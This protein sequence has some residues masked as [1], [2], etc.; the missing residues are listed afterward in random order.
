[1]KRFFTHAARRAAACGAVLLSMAFGVHAQ[2]GSQPSQQAL[3]QIAGLIAEKNA[4]TPAQQKIDSQLLYAAS[5]ARTGVASAAAPQM[6]VDGIADA[7]GRVE[8]E[9][10]GP[11]DDAM[12]ALV[13]AQGGIVVRQFPQS[14]TTEAIVPLLRLEALAADDRVAFIRPLSPVQQPNPPRPPGAADSK[15]GTGGGVGMLVDA[16]DPKAGSTVL[17]PRL[18]RFRDTVAKALAAHDASLAADVAKAKQAKIGAVTAEGDRTHRTRDVRNAFGLTG[19][20]LRIGVISDSFNNLNAYAADIASGDLPGPGNPFGYTTP[21][22]LAGSGDLPSGGS[23]EGRAML[24]IIH[25]LAPGAELY[26]ATAFNS[27]SDFANNIRA[28]RGIAASAPPFGNITPGCDIIIDDIFYF[29]ESGLHEGQPASVLSSD[30]IAEI[31]Q[32]VNDVTADG[33]LYFSSAGNSGGVTQNS[34]GAWEGDFASAGTLTIPGAPAPSDILDFDPSPAV[35]SSNGVTAASVPVMHWSDPIGASANDYDFFVLN[36]GLTAVVQSSTNVQTGTQDPVEPIFFNIAVNNRLVVVRRDTAQPR[37]ISITT[38]RGRL[39]FATT[40]QVRGHSIAPRAYAVSATPAAATFGAPTPNGPFPGPF[41]ATN[42]VEPFNSDG[43]R[44]VFFDV[45]NQPVTPG[46]FLAGTGGGA[47]RQKP[48]ITA[49]DGVATTLPP[50]SGLNPFYGTSAAAPHAGAIAALARQASPGLTPADLRLAFNATALDIMAPGVDRDSGVGIIQAF[51]LISQFNPAPV[52][53]LESGTV[54]VTRIGGSGPVEAGSSANVAVQLVNAGAAGA[55]AITATLA[56]NTPCVSVTSGSATYP[57]LAVGASAT[58]AAPFVIALSPFCICP[59]NINLTLTVSY[60]GGSQA[61]VAFPLVVDTRESLVINET[62][63]TTPPAANPAYVGANA[64]QTGRINRFTPASACGVAEAFP[65]LAATTGVRNVDT[66]TFPSTIAARCLGIALQDLTGTTAK[67]FTAAYASPYPANLTT[68]WLG[69]SGGSPS[70]GGPAATYSVS[71][72]A[73][74]SPV[75]AVHEVNVGGAPNNAYR[76]TVTGL[77]SCQFNFASVIPPGSATATETGDGDGF[78]EPC[79]RGSMAIQV[80]NRGGVAATAVTGT[81]TST[82]PGISITGGTNPFPDV[83]AGGTAANATPFTFDAAGSMTCG[84][85]A[86]FNLALAF[87]GGA[88]GGSPVNIPF[89][90]RIGAD[91]QV[92]FANGT[93]GVVPTGGTLIPGTAA[94]DAVALVEAP[95][96]VAVYSTQIAAGASLTVSTNGNLQLAASGTSSAFTNTV[97]PAAVFPA[98]PTLF[99][100]WDDL[101]LTTGGVFSLVEGTAPNRTWTLIWRGVTF[102]GANAVEFA[103]RFRERGF[104]FEY[105]YNNAAAADGVAATIGVQAAGTGTLFTQR[106]FNAAGTV[107][108]GTVFTGRAA[109]CNAC[110]QIFSNGFEP[111]STR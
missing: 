16:G 37:F 19:A 13:R 21:V 40:G 84:T 3:T 45:N 55:T 6:R 12:A 17:T 82:T 36:S 104:E 106:A 83:P 69:D 70:G 91:P 73:G 31:T 107:A 26:Y 77:N 52:A 95:F 30:G 53:T 80:A 15:S 29:I 98:A 105:L 1:M 51:Q 100:Y 79:E 88:S 111:A 32:A 67:I 58:G 94:D 11:A 39:Q 102:T 23:D 27:Q 54:T 66:Y 62:L 7:Q 47:V 48:D 59:L 34:A 2:G 42:Q 64:T 85:I 96:P 74:T 57:N 50:G 65:G 46:N 93:G 43:P 78:V 9:L 101:D 97:L 35:S 71:V 41:V 89:S 8:V 76:L 5:Q 92:A 38:N 110:P 10:R 72:P 90:V 4:R 63:D 28:L 24:Q 68:G 99:P 81:I 75:I 86:N 61:S 60:A 56:S 49:A 108:A 25:D 18:A 20:G 33:A 22:R 109:P 103:V 87:S 44:R 14:R